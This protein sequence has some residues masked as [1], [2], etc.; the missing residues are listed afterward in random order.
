MRDLENDNP[1]HVSRPVAPDRVSSL[2]HHVLARLADRGASAPVSD[3][4]LDAFC[5]VLCSNDAEAAD[6]LLSSVLAGRAGY[7]KLADGILS[8]AARRVGARWQADL[9]SFADVSI[10]VGQ[11]LRLSQSHAQRHVPLAIDRTQRQA[12][13]VTLPGQAHNLG[14]ILAAEAFRQADWQVTLMLD[15]SAQ[16]VLERARRIRPRTVGLSLSRL[17]RAHQIHGLIS[18]LYDLPYRVRVVLGGGA[19]RDF[20]AT[21]PRD[22]NVAV[23]DDICSALELA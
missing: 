3:A 20:A 15:T 21:L 7:A 11:I 5:T 12:L 14:L 9:V 6:R 16:D 17:D 22:W 8:A 10:A 18:E 2:A 4:C 19:A 1:N 23:A 13:F